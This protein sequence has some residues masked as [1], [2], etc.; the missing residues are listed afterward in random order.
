M[1]NDKMW[2]GRLFSSHF[3]LGMLLVLLSVVLEA[4][5]PQPHFILVTTISFIQT[6]GIAIVVAVIF[7]YTAGT[8]EFLE[9][10]TTLLKSIVI[11]RNFLANI[12]IDSKRSALVALIKPSE[13]ERQRYA[14]IGTY[15]DI[16]I[17]HTLNITKKCVRSDYRLEAR[18]FVD[19]DG[20][21]A[22]EQRVSYRLHPT[23]DGYTD[24]TMRLDDE[25]LGSTY[26]WARVSDP[27]GN[28][29]VSDLPAPQSVSYRGNTTLVSKIPLRELGKGKDHLIVQ[30][31]I[32][33][34]GYDH[35]IHLTFQALEP[36]DGF[37]YFLT[38]ENDLH[39]WAFQ[40]FVHG[41]DFKVY[42]DNDR[43]IELS[44]HEWFN[45]GTGVAIVVSRTQPPQ[46]NPTITPEQ[47][48]LAVR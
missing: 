14:H 1:H 31:C 26:K 15:Y 8:A 45:E 43:R 38:C 11:D 21:V 22:V 20:V 28:V 16:F 5:I 25:L 18:A 44:C 34:K 35:W 37:E 13:A 30:W 12:D 32:I 42:R 23:I 40:T 6:I 36:T 33:E 10:I 19:A 47:C 24:I 48:V 7:T 46:P 3:W 17:N 2:L 27:Q 29:L 41:A 39:I 9:K 4:T